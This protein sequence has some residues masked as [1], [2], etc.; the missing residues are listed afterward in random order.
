MTQHIQLVLLRYI[1]EANNTLSTSFFEIKHFFLVDYGKEGLY[2]LI[3]HMNYQFTINNEYGILA[4]TTREE[5][6]VHYYW[7]RLGTQPVDVIL[8]VV[9]DTDEALIESLEATVKKV[10]A[11]LTNPIMQNLNCFFVLVFKLKTLGLVKVIHEV[12]NLVGLLQHLL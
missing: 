12:F 8:R 6:Q 4:L 5:G 11:M 10:V 3:C 9:D 1:Q 2:Y 7:C